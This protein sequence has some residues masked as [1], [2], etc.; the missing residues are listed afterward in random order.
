MIGSVRAFSYI[1][2]NDGGFAPNP[3]HGVCTLACCKPKIRERAAVGDIIIGLSRRS[4]RIVYAMRV[5]RVLGFDAYWRDER[6][7]AKRPAWDSSSAIDRAGDNIYEPVAAG[8]RQHPSHHSHPD[9]REW[10]RRKRKDLGGVNVLV[11]ERFTYFGSE[12]PPLPPQLG[13]IRIGRGH[14]S[15]F[16]EQQLAVIDTWLEGLPLGVHG[17]PADWPADAPSRTRAVHCEPPRCD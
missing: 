12:G 17:R 11:A 10:P 2:K 8:F 4:E 5:A 6:Y 7:R 16:D 14:R 3:F 13:F 15:R 1:V 9:G